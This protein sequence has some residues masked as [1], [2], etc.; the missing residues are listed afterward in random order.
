MKISD[1]PQQQTNSL[2]DLPM[3]PELVMQLVQVSSAFLVTLNSYIASTREIDRRARRL[4]RSRMLL[5]LRLLQLRE[6]KHQ[7]SLLP[8]PRRGGLPPW[9]LPPISRYGRI[10]PPQL[11]PISVM[12]VCY[13]SGSGRWMF[14]VSLKLSSRKS[15]TS[16]RGHSATCVM[17][18]SQ[19][20]WKRMPIWEW[21]FR[22]RRE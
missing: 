15:S 10:F 20:S 4:R 19:H 12:F 6:D 16:A 17:R 5:L 7:R 3:P 22:W 1:P 18:W 2:E 14:P 11:Q 13:V 8:S 21:S 9:R